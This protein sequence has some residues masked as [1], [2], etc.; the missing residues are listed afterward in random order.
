MALTLLSGK[1][2][3]QAALDWRILGTSECHLHNGS[4]QLILP[5]AKEDTSSTCAS[6]SQPLPP[7][8]LLCFG[9]LLPCCTLVYGLEKWASYTLLFPSPDRAGEAAASRMPGFSGKH[10]VCSCFPAEDFAAGLLL[11]HSACPLLR[12]VTLA[13]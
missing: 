6:R 8:C 11:H 3:V 4:S 7:L 13:D 5:E 1:N 10:Q 2:L 9:V 12:L